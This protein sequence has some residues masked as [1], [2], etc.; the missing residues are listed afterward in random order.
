MQSCEMWWLM[1]DGFSSRC[2]VK[3]ARLTERN[4]F[5]AMFQLTPTWDVDPAVCMA[6]LQLASKTNGPLSVHAMRVT[7]DP[8]H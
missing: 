7:F 4:V 3:V 1:V 5:G 2:L 6:E 8:N